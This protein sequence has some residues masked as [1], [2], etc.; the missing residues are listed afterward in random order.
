MEGWKDGMLKEKECYELRVAGYG[1]LWL[2]GLLGF[3]ELLR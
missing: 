1:P 3:V 2:F